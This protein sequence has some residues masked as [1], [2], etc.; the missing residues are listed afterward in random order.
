MKNEPYRIIVSIDIDTLTIEC[1]QQ[2]YNATKDKVI[3]IYID[4]KTARK[5]LKQKPYKRLEQTMKDNVITTIY[6]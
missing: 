4:A 6:A 5:E 3:T 1:K 2:F